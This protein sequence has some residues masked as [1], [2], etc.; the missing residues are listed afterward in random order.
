[1]R[2]LYYLTQLADGMLKVHN[3]DINV[4]I[5]GLSPP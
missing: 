1:M 2:S 3:S 4:S 5:L